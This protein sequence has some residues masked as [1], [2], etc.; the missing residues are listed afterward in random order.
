ML[1]HI[2]LG[3]DTT[4]DMHEPNFLTRNSQSFFSVPWLEDLAASKNFR[5]IFFIR[6]D[7]IVILLG[8]WMFVCKTDRVN[9]SGF[10]FH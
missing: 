4:V 3:K 2:L 10:Y 1:Q 6:L 7:V 5:F 8:G 9:A